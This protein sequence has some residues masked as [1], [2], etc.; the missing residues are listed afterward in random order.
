MRR[1]WRSKKNIFI[2]LSIVLIF[3]IFIG[4][5]KHLDQ[6]YQKWFKDQMMFEQTEIGFEI[7]SLKSS[8]NIYESIILEPDDA[9]GLKILESFDEKIGL[10]TRWYMITRNILNERD[11]FE[12]LVYEIER[13]KLLLE[14]HESGEKDVT[15][16]LH[17]G[18]NPDYLNSSVAVKSYLYENKI[19][20]LS[21]PFEMVGHNFM[22]KVLSY[23]GLLLWAIV[24]VLLVVDVFASDLES[25]AYKS[26]YTVNG[27]RIQVIIAKWLSSIINVLGLFILFVSMF[28]LYFYLTGNLGDVNYPVSKSLIGTM[29]WINTL[30]YVIPL[31][32]LSLVFV[33]T[34]TYAVSMKIKEVGESFVIVIAILFVDFI[35]RG[36]VPLSQNLWHYYPLTGLDAQGYFN[37]GNGSGHI[38]TLILLVTMTLGA[39]SLYKFVHDDL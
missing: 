16:Y 20:P 34:L 36:F 31:S 24:T 32:I 35:L 37:Y 3:I 18:S 14:I 21:S 29:P 8:K 5:N 27:N 13:D 33:I 7:Q 22:S 10:Q 38:M 2:I 25:G 17:A 23:Q 11:R 6:Q 28:M 26:I 4:V 39:A 19:I 30:L 15:P 9:D 1:F 12:R